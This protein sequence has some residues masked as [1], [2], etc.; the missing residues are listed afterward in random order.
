M[1]YA[2][3]GL[4]VPFAEMGKSREETDFLGGGRRVRRISR[5]FQTCVV[6]ISGRKSASGG[7]LNVWSGAQ[8]RCLGLE[9]GIF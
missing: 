9:R 7:K 3:L 6:E 8:Q 4:E 1:T 2:A 5:K